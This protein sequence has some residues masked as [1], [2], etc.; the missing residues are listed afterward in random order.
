MAITKRIN[1]FQSPNSRGKGFQSEIRISFIV[2]VYNDEK[3]VG[4]AIASIL[5]QRIP[6]REGVQ[7]VEPIVEIIVVDDG[8]TEGSARVVRERFPEI[9][10]VTQPNGGEASALNEGLKHCTG[11]FVAIVEADVAL[12]PGWLE[13]LS[14]E[15][16]DP[17][18]MGAGGY[19]VT[20]PSDPWIARIA[21]YE[22]E[23]KF[24]TK[25]RITGHITSANALYRREAFERFG[26]FDEHLRNAS[27][28][29]DFNSRIVAGGYKLIYNKDARAQHHY[30][31]RFSDY[32]RR[33][34]AY[35]RYRMY[36]NTLALYP[37]DRFLMY[38]VGCT[39]LA[40]LS[41]IFVPFYPWVTITMFAF[42]VVLQL[43]QT[44][45]LWAKH[46]DRALIF[47]PFVMLA[48]NMVAV[49]GY[50]IGTLCRR[51]GIS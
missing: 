11:N 14:A 31:P 10:L 24:A 47:H 50:A 3:T 46:K 7:N 26:G 13:I 27:L 32:L 21:G 30:K 2:P 9:T 19:L 35:A 41:L 45:R 1:N 18:V 22:V 37:A 20:P 15:F 33:Q 29:S 49:F 38:N 17:F 5:S 4:K 39:G 28:D 51:S 42:V 23:L 48:R 8:S 25:E 34:Y 43:P 16:D 36:V 12:Y 40:L 44:W 6:D